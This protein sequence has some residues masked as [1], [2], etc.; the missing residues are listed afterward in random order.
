MVA[1]CF[2]NLFLDVSQIN[3]SEELEFKLEK[4][5]GIQKHARKVRKKHFPSRNMFNSYCGCQTQSQ[6][7][8]FFSEGRGFVVGS[9]LVEPLCTPGDA[10]SL[11][12][13]LSAD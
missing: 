2:L 12:L 1:E 5:I 8:K 11:K 3:R 13:T 7:G 10:E 6:R 4:I 9:Y